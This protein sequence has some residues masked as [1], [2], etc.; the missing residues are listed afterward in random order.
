MN[1]LLKHKQQPVTVGTASPGP[2]SPVLARL[3][4]FTAAEFTALKPHSQRPILR[5]FKVHPTSS[6]SSY[7]PSCEVSGCVLHPPS[8]SSVLWSAMMLTWSQC[9]EGSE[10]G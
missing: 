8:S 10:T 4:H 6:C 1:K 9:S 7:P 5:V 2:A 3:H